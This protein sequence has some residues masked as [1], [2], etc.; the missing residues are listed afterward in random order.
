M[1]DLQRLRLGQH[2]ISHI[3]RSAMQRGLRKPVAAFLGGGV[4]QNDGAPLVV[5][6]F[7]G[8]AEGRQ[9]LRGHVMGAGHGSRMAAMS[10]IRIVAGPPGSTPKK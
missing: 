1:I 8:G 5:Q 2:S 4:V 3:V 9:A 6:R 10:A 7:P